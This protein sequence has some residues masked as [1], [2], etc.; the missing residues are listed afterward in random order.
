MTNDSG[1]KKKTNSFL[2][3]IKNNARDLLAFFIVGLG[4]SALGAVLD[5][6]GT[7]NG[8]NKFISLTVP[9]LAVYLQGFSRFIGASLTATLFWM[10]LW[11]TVDRFGNHSFSEAW[12]SLSLQQKFLTYVGLVSVALLA[13]SNCFS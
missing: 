1:D 3:S 13:A 5:W 12:E 2:D 7:Y 9:A 8:D 11:P 10:L 4:I 6:V